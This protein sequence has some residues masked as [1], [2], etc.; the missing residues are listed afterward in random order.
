M[1]E[2]GRGGMCYPLMVGSCIVFFTIISVLLLKERMRK[3]QLAAILVCVA[4]LVL[5]CTGA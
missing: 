1:A 3:I 4:G 5:I 2:Q